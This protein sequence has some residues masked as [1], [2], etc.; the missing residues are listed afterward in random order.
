MK[1]CHVY[2]T[3]SVAPILIMGYK[4]HKIKRRYSIFIGKF[5]IYYIRTDEIDY[6]SIENVKGDTDGEET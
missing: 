4:R 5:Y 6:F 2:T 3:R 1:K